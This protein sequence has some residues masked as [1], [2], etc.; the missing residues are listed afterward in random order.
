MSQAEADDTEWR[1]TD[2]GGKLKETGTSHWESPN[3]GATNET[4]F[5]ALPGGGIFFIGDFSYIGY[6]GYW[7]TATEESVDNALERGLIFG[8]HCIREEIYNKEC[9][10]SVRLVKD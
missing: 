9:G 1:G 7:W 10:F 2:E 5:T 4:G 8:L 3:T 6:Y